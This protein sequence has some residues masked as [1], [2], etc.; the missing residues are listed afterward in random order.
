MWYDIQTKWHEDGYRRSSNIK[1]F[2]SE[3]SEAVMLVLLMGGIYE[4]HCCDGLRCI[5]IYAKLHTHWFRH[6]AVAR[7]LQVH[8]HRDQGGLISLLL[9]FK[10]MANW[11]KMLQGTTKQETD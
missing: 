7:G 5:N 11:I 2:A 9:S 8:T 1:V 6:S 3:I 10:N 4:V